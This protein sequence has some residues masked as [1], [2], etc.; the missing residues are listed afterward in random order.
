MNKISNR[1]TLKYFYTDLKEKYPS[2]F[3]KWAG[4]KR[5]LI[6][7]MNKFFPRYFNKYIEPFVG[8]G[9][10]FF[11]LYRKNYLL[12]KKSILIDNNEDLINTYKIIKQ[13]V[14]NLIKSLRLH[15]YE[16]N[17]YYRIRNLDRDPK[18][19]MKLSEI[20]KASRLIYLNKSGYNGLYR[21]NSKGQ[22][23]VPFGRHKNPNICDEKNLRA[24]NKSLK[25]VKIIH[26]SF[27]ICLNFA[28]K[29]DFI[30]LDPPYYPIS[31]TALFTSYTKQDFGRESQLKLFEVF[32][33]LNKKGC[34]LLLSNSYCKFILNLYKD[35]K[36]TI[37]KAKRAINCNSSKRGIVN[38]ILVSNFNF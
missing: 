1:V 7:Q 22:F 29:D 28:E 19:Y 4:G 25:G 6:P 13:D 24:V 17:Y 12:N 8:G 9:A 21:V 18:K 2:P 31:D 35:F 30:Y 14:L 36:I 26:N 27:E 5:Q 33:K 20:D 32:K 3:L 38:E 23:N 37:L 34:K 15:Q 16:K 11:Y 10:I